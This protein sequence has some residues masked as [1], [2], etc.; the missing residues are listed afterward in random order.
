MDAADVVDR[1]GEQ[2]FELNSD[3]K[4]AFLT[5]RKHPDRIVL[6]HTEVPK[7]LEGRGM[8]GKLARAALDY[9][10]E[11]KLKVV[12][13]CPFVTEYIKRH[14]EYADLV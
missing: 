4:T 8:G 1:E 5:Y 12:V 13:K 10:R 3:G 11:K 14:P 7:E 9:A 6:I 2:R